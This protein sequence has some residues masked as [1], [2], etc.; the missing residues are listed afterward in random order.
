MNITRTRGMRS[1]SKSGFLRDDGDAMS[2][3]ALRP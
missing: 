2:G 1:A 3:E